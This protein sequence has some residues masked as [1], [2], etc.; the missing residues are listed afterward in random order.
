[1]QLQ[2]HSQELIYL[3]NIDDFNRTKGAYIKY[4]GGVAG[5]FYKFF[6]KFS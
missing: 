6:K 3:V 5:G 2:F 4:V 1:M